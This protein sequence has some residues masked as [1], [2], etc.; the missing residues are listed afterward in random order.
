MKPVRLVIVDDA[1]FVREALSRLLAADDRIHVVATAATGEEL[2]ARLDEW[3]PD[4][5]TLDLEMPGLGGL[6]TLDRLAERPEV[7]VIIMSTRSGEGAPVTIEA[8][9]RGAADFVDKESLSLVDFRALRE[10]LVTK[11]LHVTGREVADPPVELGLPAPVRPVRPVSR[12]GMRLLVVGASTGGPR[13]V[14]HLLRS[15]APVG[16][17]VLIAQHMPP[18][19][20][21]AFAERLNRTLPLDVAEARHDEGLLPGMVRIAPGGRHLAVAASHG[22]LRSQILD[23]PADTLHR[24]CVDVLFRS[25][26]QAV[27]DEAVAVLLTGMGSDG[28]AGMALLAAAGAPTI[29]QDEATCVVYGMPR[30]AVLMGAAGDELPLDAI[31]PRIHELMRPTG[32]GR[33][34]LTLEA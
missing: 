26:A 31:G 13:A 20:T 27:G 10:V 1:R 19:F 22:R 14:E 25:A 34:T 29:A 9:A 23:D 24:P 16:V 18:G 28:A 17:P 11:L 32:V 4:A 3:R 30:A 6:A 2:L 33:Q 15:L 12:G 8:L 5:V 7:S 21:R